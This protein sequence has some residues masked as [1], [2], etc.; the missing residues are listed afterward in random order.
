[1]MGCRGCGGDRLLVDRAERYAA[2]RQQLHTT[3]R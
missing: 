1:M 2:C 3:T